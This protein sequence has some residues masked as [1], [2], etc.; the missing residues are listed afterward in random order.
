MRIPDNWR[1][2]LPPAWPLL[3]LALWLV[4][5]AGLR[6]VALPDEGRYGEIGRAHV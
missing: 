6:P 3:A 2:R 5:L 4:A 1:H